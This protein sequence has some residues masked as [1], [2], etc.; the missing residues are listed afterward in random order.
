MAKT[1]MKNRELKRQRTV[2][3]YAKKRAELK[4]TIVNPETSPE[5]RWEAQVALQKQP[6]D[7]SASRLR[8]RCRITGRPHGVFRKFGLS[9][10][11]LREAAMRGDVPGLVKASW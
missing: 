5:A 6:R 10:I 7:A 1:S 4:A 3:K 8:N 11:K 2:A 9:R